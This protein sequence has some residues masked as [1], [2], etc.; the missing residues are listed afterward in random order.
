M[1]ASAADLFGSFGV[2]A[3]SFTNL[4]AESGAPRGS[5]YHYFPGGKQQLVREALAWTS[6]RIVAYQRQC[7]ARTPEEVVEHFV[8]LF[9]RSLIESKCRAGCPVAAT[10]LGFGSRDPMTKRSVKAALRAWINL[11]ASQFQT[12]GLAAVSARSLATTTVA[13]VEG[14]LILCRAEGSIAPL[15]SIRNPLRL[16]SQGSF[17]S[18]DADES[19]H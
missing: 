3:S 18:P 15:D 8:G 7:R 16:I 2:E 11:L 19:R 10:A 5:I 9:R 13:V 14:A 1:V 17:R 12:S 4:L 6:R